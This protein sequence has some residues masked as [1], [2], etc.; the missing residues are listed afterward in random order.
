M[1]LLYDPDDAAPLTAPGAHGKPKPKRKKKLTKRQLEQRV[2]AERGR[3]YEMRNHALRML[4]HSRRLLLS[5][6]EDPNW[7]SANDYHSRWCT[8]MLER[9]PFLLER[10][11]TL[12]DLL[13][14]D[15]RLI[16]WA[17]ADYLKSVK[18][19]EKNYGHL[20]NE[21]KLEDPS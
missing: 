18:E 5:A 19:Y 8:W 11:P 21:L 6:V 4:L 9:Y 13:A 10:D 1:S 20:P 16:A 3:V 7:K 15:H 14:D 12:Q 17:E 2:L